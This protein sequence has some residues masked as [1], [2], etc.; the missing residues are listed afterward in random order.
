MLR[1]K[2]ATEYKRYIRGHRALHT[3]DGKA[4]LERAY[5]EAKQ[6]L[7]DIQGLVK[8]YVITGNVAVTVKAVGYNRGDLDNIVKAVNDSAQG[9]VFKDDK[10]V[11]KIN[12]TRYN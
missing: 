9:L 8:N 5:D 10:Q 1:F 2:N 3:D 6:A 4:G 12:A 7:R 11:Q